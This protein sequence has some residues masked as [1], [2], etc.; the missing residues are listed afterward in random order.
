MH[1]DEKI[2][3]LIVDALAEKR[4]A[5]ESILCELGENIVVAASGE[6]A[7]FQVLRYEFAVILLA[8]HMPNIDG[9]ETAA[10]I[11][12]HKKAAHVPIIFLTPQL[13]DLHLARGY[14]LGAADYLLYPVN[15]EILRAKVRVFVE[16]CKLTQQAKRHADE[17][18]AIMREQ[19][20]RMAAEAAREAKEAAYRRASFLAEISAKLASSLD[21]EAMMRCLVRMSVPLLADFAS[22]SLT[23]ERGR[24]LRT[25]LAW[26]Q[27]GDGLPA[28]LSLHDA[29][30]P[31]ALL[32]GIRRAVVSGHLERIENVPMQ[33]SSGSGWLAAGEGSSV[34]SSFT[35][36]SV[37]ILPLRMRDHPLGALIF[38]M[39]HPDRQFG[40][41]ENLQAEALASRAAAFLDNA[42]L[43]RNIQ[44]SDTRKTEFLSM[45]AHE[46]RNP[47]AAIRG[48]VQ[49]L[50]LSDLAADKV[51]WAR[52]IIDRQVSQLVRLVDDLLDVARITQGKVKLQ[53]EPIELAAVVS[54]AAENSVPLIEAR[55]HR[56]SVSFKGGPLRVVG[57]INRLSQVITTL[58]HNA[59]KHTDTGGQIWL[60]LEQERGWV[61]LRVRDNGIGL[62][63]HMLDTIFELFTQPHFSL[64]RAQGGI[65]IGLT[66]VR[67]LVEMH[68]GSVAVTSKG[69]NQGCEFVVRLPLLKEDSPVETVPGAGQATRGMRRRVLIV[70]DNLEIVESLVIMLESSG[71]EVCMAHD[72]S[73]ALEA[74][75]AFG[76]Q[77]VIL[78]I[79]LPGLDGYEVARHLR[80]LPGLSDTL[81]IALTGYGQTDARRRAYDAGFDLHLVKPVDLKTLNDLMNRPYPLSLAE[82]LNELR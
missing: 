19:A 70:D 46:L 67:H 29:S 38:G 69:Q 20:A 49:V 37:L 13:D 58:L 6:E 71:H 11:R 21:E 26:S 54:L 33:C 10:L 17:R 56:L 28:T 31:G 74:A 42:C 79:G 22:V 25:E 27:A 77:V 60:S 43:S 9:Y 76:P 55:R 57:D 16:L 12:K 8:V 53:M 34:E 5:L 62:P 14:S 35:L 78:D 40:P 52:A 2:N 64:D 7:L 80:R 4:L 18:V 24:I 44:E 41:E 63:K 45:L 39:A 23:S 72:G 48:A 1:I 59:A 61:L 36:R 3:I 51:P 15:S 75:Q 81:L 30:L 73:A 66:L 82:P 65:G 68:G 32:D 50:C 47:L